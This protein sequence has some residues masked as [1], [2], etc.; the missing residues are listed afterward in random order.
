MATVQDA[1]FKWRGY[2]T[3]TLPE[4]PSWIETLGRVGHIANGVVYFIIGFL[5]FKLAIGAGGEISGSK[6]AIRSIGNQPFGQV[7][8]ILTAIGLLGYAAW[9]FVQG[10]KDTDG[11]G[12]DAEGLVKRTGYIVSG[13]GYAVL[14]VYA[15][16][17]VIGSMSGS[18]S[19]SQ[20]AASPL[21]DSTWGRVLL[22]IAGLIT[23]GTGGY[24][25]Y[26]AY[27]AKFMGKYNLSS[28]SETLRT[29]ALHAGRMG[30]STRGI[31][32]AIIGGFL[33]MSA[34][35]GTSNGKIAGMEDALAAIASQPYGKTMLGIVGF[36]L[37]CYAV[38]MFLM[39]WFRRFNVKSA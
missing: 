33:T 11:A 9:R 4:V 7:L 36:G 30:Y 32:F 1:K 27:K 31:A 17:L 13:I 35:R 6:E 37:M 8:L 38:H 26:K 16:S 28:M 2:T 25:I 24:F 21:L 39:G 29:V 10:G 23:I 22:G 12:D 18:S 14:G 15:G 19:D 34:Y 5:A 20:S 3:H